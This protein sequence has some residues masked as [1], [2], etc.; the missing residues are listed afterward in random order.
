MFT[1]VGVNEYNNTVL[2]SFDNKKVSLASDVLVGCHNIEQ[3][4]LS[5]KSYIK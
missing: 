5:D 1:N 2:N 4:T 3:E